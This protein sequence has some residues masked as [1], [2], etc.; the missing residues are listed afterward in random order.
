MDLATAWTPC[1]E[2]GERE[3]DGNVDRA[4]DTSSVGTDEVDRRGIMAGFAVVIWCRG[5]GDQNR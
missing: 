5:I 4:S 2:S 3:T 1:K